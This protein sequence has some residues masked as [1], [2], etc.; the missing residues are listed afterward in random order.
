M[1]AKGFTL[2]ELMIVVVIVG[3]LAAVA[4]FSIR[5]YMNS[6]RKSEVLAIFGEIRVKE[7]A[8]HAEFSRYLSTGANDTSYYPVPNGT[9]QPWTPP[10]AWT[11]LGISPG[12][13]QVYCGYAVTAG[14]RGVAPAPTNAPNWFGGA[15]MQSDWWY[16]TASCDNDRNPAVNAFFLTSSDNSSV[17]EQ[18]VQR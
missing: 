10:A 7:E 16:A 18:N 8:Y 14:G 9:P 17:F 3:L 5:R 11:Q 6:A 4:V 1:R 2:V 12:K 15:A 13:N